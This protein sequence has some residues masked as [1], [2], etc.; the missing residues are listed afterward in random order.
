MTIDEFVD[1]L[2]KIE[3]GAFKD[4]YA[5]YKNGFG[6]FENMYANNVEGHKN[7]VNNLKLYLK[8]MLEIKPKYLLVGEAPG[9]K[10]CRWSGIPFTSEKNLVK[11]KFFGLQNGFKVRNVKKA[12][13]EQTSTIVWNCLD[14]IGIYPLLWDAFPFHPCANRDPETE[15]LE[16]GKEFL[17]EIMSIFDILP[18]N[19][20]AAGNY[21]KKSLESFTGF[22]NIEIKSVPLPVFGHKSPFVKGLKNYLK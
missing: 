7:T 2:V 1:G 17:K 20:I 13:T 6:A 5:K 8:K 9:Y 12:Q 19:V 15:E 16:F 11:N 18:E 22:K 3:T 21:A 10:G 4:I 14:D